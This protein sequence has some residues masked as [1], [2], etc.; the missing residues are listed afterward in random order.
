MSLEINDDT[1]HGLFNW[2]RVRAIVLRIMFVGVV[3]VCLV[4][5]CTPPHDPSLEIAYG[6]IQD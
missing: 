5:A 2:K 6:R 1:G 4:S 3:V